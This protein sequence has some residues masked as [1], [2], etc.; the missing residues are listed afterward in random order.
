MTALT[1]KPLPLKVLWWIL[2]LGLCFI[3]YRLRHWQHGASQSLCAAG[4]TRIFGS[5]FNFFANRWILLFKKTHL[6]KLNVL[7]LLVCYNYSNWEKQWLNTNHTLTS[8]WR[9]GHIYVSWIPKKEKPCKKNTLKPSI[10][11]WQLRRK[12]AKWPWHWMTHSHKP[13][14]YFSMI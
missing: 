10:C 9:L 7:H 2:T 5:S 11:T 6:G 1:N 13:L 8:C 3:A 12:C 4:L 14:R